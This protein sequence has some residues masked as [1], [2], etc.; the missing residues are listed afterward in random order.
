MT[1]PRKYSVEEAEK[2]LSESYFVDGECDMRLLTRG[3]GVMYHLIHERNEADRGVPATYV[4]ITDSATDMA[5]NREIYLGFLYGQSTIEQS[6]QAFTQSEINL[7]EE[8]QR[9]KEIARQEDVNE[10]A[11]ARRFNVVHTDGSVTPA[12]VP[13]YLG[14]MM[15]IAGSYISS[16]L[17]LK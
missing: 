7:Q 9:R 13:S 5:I 2:L 17:R 12:H 10:R 6:L 15:Q 3:L 16:L 11:A 14:Q 1:E 8:Y 4:E